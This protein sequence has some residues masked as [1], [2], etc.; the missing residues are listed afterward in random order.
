MKKKNKGNKK[1]QRQRRRERMK[2]LP[3]RFSQKV[4]LIDGNFSYYPRAFCEYYDAFLT[5]GLIN[6]HRCDKRH[7]KRYTNFNE[8]EII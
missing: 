8:N 7:C 3:L 6:T 4:Q 5:D 1:R 2:N